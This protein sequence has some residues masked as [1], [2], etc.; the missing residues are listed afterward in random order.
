LRNIKIYGICTTFH[1][2]KSKKRKPKQV[3]QTVNIHKCIL[4]L[5][6]LYQISGTNI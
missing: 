1:W 3:A 5:H 4:C 2:T 6:K